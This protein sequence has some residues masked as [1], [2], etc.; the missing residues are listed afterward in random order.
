MGIHHVNCVVISSHNGEIQLEKGWIPNPEKGQRA[1]YV[2]SVRLP[3][4]LVGVLE[5][6][7]KI[8]TKL[9]SLLSK[10][11]PLRLRN[12][13]QAELASRLFAPRR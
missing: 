12:L 2:R 11:Q 9:V 10:I 4:G 13:L 7:E 8:L 1:K 5:T 3:L 6:R